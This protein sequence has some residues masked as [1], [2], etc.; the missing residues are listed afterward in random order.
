MILYFTFLYNTNRNQCKRKLRSCY[1]PSSI[2]SI[3]LCK[4][5]QYADNNHSSF[6]QSKLLN[7]YTIFSRCYLSLNRFKQKQTRS[8]IS[9]FGHLS[10]ILNFFRTRVTFRN[11]LCWL[12]LLRLLLRL[13]LLLWLLLLL[14]WPFDYS[15]ISSWFGLV[16]LLCS[17]LSLLNKSDMKF[18]QQFAYKYRSAQLEND[19]YLQNW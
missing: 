18:D 17:T 15:G 2:H 10:L 11:S 3:W 6:T 1:T 19:S 4:R 7:F 13:L 14:L 5:M 8:L 16:C 12:L 9:F